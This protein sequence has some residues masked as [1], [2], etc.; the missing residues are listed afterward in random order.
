MSNQ[1]SEIKDIIDAAAEEHWQ[2]CNA[3]VD[4]GTFIGHAYKPDWIS[5]ITPGA[6]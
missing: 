2:F 5:D 1:T 6:F 4:T 3:E